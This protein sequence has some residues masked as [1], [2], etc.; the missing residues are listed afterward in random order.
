MESLAYL[1]MELAASEVNGNT[2]ELDIDAY[3][4][5]YNA[6]AEIAREGIDFDEEEEGEE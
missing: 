6:I 1:H 3:W 5:A 4:E 2:Q